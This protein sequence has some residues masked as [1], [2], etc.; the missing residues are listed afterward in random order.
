MRTNSTLVWCG[1][2]EWAQISA[3]IVCHVSP[4]TEKSALHRRITKCGFPVETATPSTVRPSV[5]SHNFARSTGNP[6]AG[7]NFDGVAAIG[8]YVVDAADAQTGVCLDLQL[9][10]SLCA[11]HCA[12]PRGNATGAVAADLRDRA[13]CIVQA[14]SCRISNQSRQRTRHRPLP[15]PCCAHRDCASVVCPVAFGCSSLRS[16]SENHCRTRAPW[17]RESIFLRIAEVEQ[18]IDRRL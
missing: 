9:V 11:D 13:V 12:H 14:D 10:A 7:R 1:K 2:S 3:P 8:K 17:Q 5:N 18:R 6:H 15:R 16:Q 4:A